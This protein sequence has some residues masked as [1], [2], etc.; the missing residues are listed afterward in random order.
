[1][2]TYCHERAA[3]HLGIA[4]TKD[5]L[6][7]TFY[8]PNCYRKVEAF[9]KSY[10]LCQRVGKPQ[11]K[12]KAPLKLVPVITEIFSK[13]NVDAVGPLPVTP[14]G[15][16]Y[17][18]TA[19]CMS[20]KYPD[21]I[22]VEN[23]K[24]TSI[25]DALLQ[26]FSR[27]GFPKELQTDQGTSFTSALTTEFLE[28]FG[29]KVVRSSVYHPQSNPVER[30]HRTLKRILRVLCL[31]S[32]P[33]WEKILPQALFA[34]RTVTHDSTGFTPAELVHGR[35]LKTPVTLLYDKL[36]EE[37]QEEDCVVNYVFELMNRM[38]NVKS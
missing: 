14:S 20:S 19:V 38:E 12:K 27:M 10:D 18:I 2:M 8:W 34:L 35:N 37:D 25:I 6:F 1:M 4:K 29:I 21:A 36:T 11:D 16:K 13:I 9:V 31:E 28:R 30:M 3:S 15:N 24:S 23:L 22:P 33:D 7:K 26:V 5:A 17:L 32:G